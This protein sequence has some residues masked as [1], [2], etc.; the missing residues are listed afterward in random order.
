M[1]IISLPNIYS[2]GE[3]IDAGQLNSNLSTIVNDYNGNIQNVNLSSSIAITDNKLNQIQ[4][5]AKVNGTALTNLSGI[6]AGAGVIPTANL[7][8]FPQYK[9]ILFTQNLSTTT[10]AVSTTGVGFRPKAAIFMGASGNTLASFNGV[11]DGTTQGCVYNQNGGG[12]GDVQGSNTSVMLFTTDG[13]TNISI[14][15]LTSFDA[16][17]FTLTWTKTGSPT[18][19]VSISVLCFG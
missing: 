8:T 7:P 11:T 4:S 6:P 13:F 19:T 9:V 5:A 15:V 10:G 17:G 16:D 1:A 3:V 18:G 2:N 14:A 12:T